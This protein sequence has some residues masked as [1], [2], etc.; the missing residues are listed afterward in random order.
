MD[1]ELISMII[2]TKTT[3]HACGHFSL[4]LSRKGK[5]RRRLRSHA[6]YVLMSVYKSFIRGFLIFGVTLS[7][8]FM[9]R[10]RQ[11]SCDKK[12][13]SVRDSIEKKGFGKAHF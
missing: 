3:P 6:I 2:G 7:Q 9:R 11:L 4:S 8:R 1:F 5:L 10:K 13:L 12:F